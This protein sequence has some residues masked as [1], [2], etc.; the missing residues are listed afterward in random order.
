[1]IEGRLFVRDELKEVAKL[2]TLD[3]LRAQ[4]LGLIGAPAARLAGV[5]GEAGGG[6]LAMT[7]EGFR[8]GLEMDMGSDTTDKGHP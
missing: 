8:K 1:M 3:T 4:L 5:I 7:L 2:P 6:Q